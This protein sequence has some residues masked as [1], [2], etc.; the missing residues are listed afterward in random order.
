MTKFPFWLPVFLLFGLTSAALQAQYPGV[1]GAVESH[2]QVL[3]QK[4]SYSNDLVKQGETALDG[5]DY[6][7]AYAFFKSA[8]D[9]LP[10]GG[11]ASAKA[12][13]QALSGF[14]NAAVLLARQRVPHPD[15][16]LGLGLGL[17]SCYSTPVRVRVRVRDLGMAATTPKEP[18][19]I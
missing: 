10:Q 15:L 18:S 11:D 1:Q 9:T 4:L 17:Q 6:E 8:V 2:I 16:P 12:R 5:K 14:C 13:G 19:T 7:A 3:E